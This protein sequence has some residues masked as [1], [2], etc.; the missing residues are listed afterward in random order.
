MTKKKHH[1]FSLQQGRKLS[2]MGIDSVC[3]NAE[4]IQQRLLYDLAGLVQNF[5]EGCKV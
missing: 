4:T 5:T 1:G 3:S 2:K